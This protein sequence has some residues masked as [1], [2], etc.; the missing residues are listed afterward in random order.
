M[1]PEGMSVIAGARRLEDI[2][3]DMMKFI[4]ITTGYGRTGPGST[5]FQGAAPVKVDEYAN[6]LLELYGKCL[7]AVR[8]K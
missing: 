6:H 7:T 5:G 4:A 8:A 2:A 3:L 1:E